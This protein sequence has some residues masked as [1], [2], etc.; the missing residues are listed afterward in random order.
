MLQVRTYMITK[1]R[2]EN[3][4]IKIFYFCAFVIKNK[5]I[6]IKII[7]GSHT[8]RKADSAS[9]VANV[10]ENFER[11]INTAPNATPRAKCSP[12]PRRSKSR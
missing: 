3:F 7:F 9:L 8:P 6:N 11:K 12:I 2:V 10:I 1:Y 4:S 5:A